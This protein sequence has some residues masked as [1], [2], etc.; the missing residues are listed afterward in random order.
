MDQNL[1]HSDYL[2]RL[3]RKLSKESG[4]Q[5]LVDLG[6]EMLGNPFT[7]TDFSVKLLAHTGETK[8]TD[9]PV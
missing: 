1:L 7:I 8:V 5:A 6:Y 9:D 2:L 4:L 3:I